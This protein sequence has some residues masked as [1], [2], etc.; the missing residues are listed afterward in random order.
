MP[1]N[2][3]PNTPWGRSV[4]KEDFHQICQTGRLEGELLERFWHMNDFQSEMPAY[5]EILVRRSDVEKLVR[6]LKKKRMRGRE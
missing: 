3:N 1:F 4:T 2:L 6:K 5:I